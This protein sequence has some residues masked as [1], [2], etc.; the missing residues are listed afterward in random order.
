MENKHALLAVV[1]NL[2]IGETGLEKSTEYHFE[3]L[4]SFLN[5]LI[6]NDFNR[7]LSILYRMDISE[8]RLKRKL[9]ENKESRISSAEL[10]A[11]LMIDREKEKIISREK[12]K[13]P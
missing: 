1:N 4:V 3:N 7:L 10:I 12:H 5:D 2:Q 6:L 9:A 11:H 8:D 13:R